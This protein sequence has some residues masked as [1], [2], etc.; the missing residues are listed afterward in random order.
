MIEGPFLWYLNRGSGVVALVLLTAATVLGVLALGGRPGG[1]VP[2]FVTQAVHRN[3]A[4]L[5]VLLLT[6]HVVAAV[7]D[8]F[9]EIRW[10]HA[11]VPFTSTY[12]RVWMG[13][14][15]VALDLMVLVTV[16]SL[17]RRRMHYRGWRALHLSAYALWAA[18]IA[19]GIGMGTDLGDGLWLLTLVCGAVV[20]AAVTWRLTRAAADRLYPPEPAAHPSDDAMTMPIRRIP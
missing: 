8:E 7:V 6:V 11:V 18:S 3:V 14:G 2:R 1:W 9:V 12:Q 15:A 16:S 20:P 13:L 5:A 10:W 19:H 4:L 17:L